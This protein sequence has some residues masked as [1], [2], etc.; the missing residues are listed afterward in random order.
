MKATHA[1]LAALITYVLI[2]AT[3]ALAAQGDCSQPASN[4]TNPNATDCLVILRRAVGLQACNP[5]CICAPKGTLPP[6]ATDALV[7]LKKATGQNVVLNCP[8]P[9]STTTTTTTSSTTTTTIDAAGDCPGKG[10]IV[11]YAGTTG[12]DCTTNTD[13]PVGSCDTGL[14]RC[15]TAT[16]LDTG[17]TGIAFNSDINDQVTMSGNLD[18][19]N[20]FTPGV[21]EPCGVCE[22]T[23]LN[24]E[25]GNCRCSHDNQTI[26]ANVFQTDSADCSVGVSCTTALDCR[27]CSETTST[28]CAIDDECPPGELCLNGLRLPSC[29]NNQCVGTCDCFFGPPLPLS[30]G[31]TPAC[32]VNRFAEDVSGTANV[33]LGAGEISANL[34]AVVFLG[35]LTTVPC[36]YCTGDTTPRDGIRDGTCV[37]GENDG[38]ACDVDAENETFPAPGGDGHSLD[39][40]PTS[41]KNV[42]GTGLK[43]GLRQTTGDQSLTAG[44]VCGFPPFAAESCPC[45][46]CSGNGTVTCSSNTD[47]AALGFGT[48]RNQALGKPRAN[49]CSDGVCSDTGNGFDGVCSAGP[50]PTYCD[51]AFRANGEPYVTCNSNADCDAT[52]CGSGIG[53][54]LCG[55]CSLTGSRPCFLDPIQVSGEADPSFPVGASLFCIPPTSSSGINDVA[56]LPGPGRVVNQVASS[57]FCSNTP[58]A[59]YMPGVGGCP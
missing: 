50:T 25:Q 52:E 3:P 12:I 32:V 56:G 54:G 29:V 57:L 6:A 27:V 48:C 33:D 28:A 43:I 26:C 31:S 51:G 35:E 23:G 34:R 17:W 9:V 30:S 8:C 59:P 2:A 37:L 21:P 22:V 42:S 46:I 53:P 38:D 18:C 49:G 4:G 40:F 44:I 15:V 45:G 20:P 41:G 39:C 14:G 10:E 55:T 24:P 19:P 36:P 1:A 58:D 13:C 47:C 7:C 16:D 11:L 5:D